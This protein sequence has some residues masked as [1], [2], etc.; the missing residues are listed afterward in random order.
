VAY[1]KLYKKLKRQFHTCVTAR[2]SA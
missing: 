1:G 2:N